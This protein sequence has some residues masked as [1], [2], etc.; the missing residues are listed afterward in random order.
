LNQGDRGGLPRRC[1]AIVAVA[2]LM[3]ACATLPPPAVLSPDDRVAVGQITDYLNNLH[4][5]QARFTQLGPDGLSQGE[6]WLSRP[7][8]LAVEYE[9]P[10]PRAMIANR[11]RLLLADR[12]TGAITTLP[13]SRTPLDILLAPAIELTNTVTITRIARLPGAMQLSLVK[14]AAPGQG[15]L[16]LRFS[17]NILDR[18]GQTTSFDLSDFQP[19]AEIDPARFEYHAPKTSEQ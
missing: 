17:V 5:F 9:Q 16:T 3:A 2:A 7:G 1:F 18:N 13:V 15:T 12:V 11:G 4:S 19:G 6:V 14:S 10:H 8:R